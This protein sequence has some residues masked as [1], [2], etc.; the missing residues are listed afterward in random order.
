M[1]ATDMDTGNGVVGDGLDANSLRKDGIAIGPTDI[2]PPVTPSPD[3]A[4][5]GVKATG[6]VNFFPHQKDCQGLGGEG[7]NFNF[8]DP[9]SLLSPE[10][11][12]RGTGADNNLQHT[13]SD[14]AGHELNYEFNN[15]LSIDGD[16]NDS[17]TKRSFNDSYFDRTDDSFLDRTDGKLED[18][19]FVERNSKCDNHNN[20]IKENEKKYRKKT[21]GERRDVK[22]RKKE[23][24]QNYDE[25]VEDAYHSKPTYA[26][27][28]ESEEMLDVRTDDGSKLQQ[29]DF[30]WLDEGV[31]EIYARMKKEALNEGRTIFKYSILGGIYK[32]VCWFACGNKETAQLFKKECVGFL[33]PPLIRKDK[34]DKKITVTREF[35]YV[36]Y[37]ADQR[38]F[39]FMKAKVPLRYARKQPDHL[40]WLL[41]CSNDILEEKYM[42][43]DKVEK[44]YHFKVV[45]GMSG[46]ELDEDS[47]FFIVDIE[48]DEKLFKPLTGMMGKLKLGCS[49]INLQG[50][51]MVRAA[52]QAIRAKIDGVTDKDVLG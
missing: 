10:S 35:S 47:K 41:K 28:T 39:R 46:E 32:G 29:E 14:T 25:E 36:V 40:T 43:E 5:D 7:G 21:P 44:E 51:G 26:Q 49:F 1:S 33:P 38:P 13:I 3:Q 16:I 22:R 30:D 48:V 37:N 9:K 2:G 52:K 42:G 8:R 45:N 6:Q 31:L 20:S 23:A 19:T 17:A 50:G 15:C 4:G 24:E 18:R 34:D 12:I 11:S 27:L